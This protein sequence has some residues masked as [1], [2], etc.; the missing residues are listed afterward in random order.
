MMEDLK[1]I[2]NE[3]NRNFDTDYNMISFDSLPSTDLLQILL[4][5]L[6]I[7][8]ASNKLD[9]RKSKDQAIIAALNAL[10]LIKYNPT[11]P[12]DPIEFREGLI[13]G[14]RNII[15]PI[16][17]WIL[18][19]SEKV[20]KRVYFSNFVEK[21]EIPPEIFGDPEVEQMNQ[22]YNK[23]IEEF[24][25]SYNENRQEKKNAEESIE[26]QEDTKKMAVDMSFLL[27]RLEMQN[28]KL[29]NIPNRESLLAS[30]KAYRREIQQEKKMQGQL[31]EHKNLI[32]QM[33]NELKGLH[34]VLNQKM[35]RRPDNA[36]PL[37][38]IR[39]E[40]QINKILGESQLP[41]EQ[42]GIVMELDVFERVA[43]ESEPTQEELDIINEEMEEMSKIVQT[44]LARKMTLTNTND[45]QLLPFRNQATMIANKKQELSNF[46]MKVKS[47]I[48]NILEMINQKAVML[49]EI[50]GGDILHGDEL[51]NFISNLRERSIVYKK[52]RSYLQ[53]IQAE[54]GIVSR[55]LDILKL[56]D[57]GVEVAIKMKKDKL[58]D[59]T[60]LGLDDVAEL[61]YKCKML[62][63]DANSKRVESVRVY[64]DMTQLRAAYNNFLDKFEETKT[65]FD[66]ATG[67]ISKE[68]E[69][70]E[71]M[72]EENAEAIKNAENEWKHIVK[73]IEGYEMCLGKYS[74]IKNGGV[75]NVLLQLKEK[76]AE[77]E[78]SRKVLEMKYE[79]VKEQKSLEQ[80]AIEQLKRIKQMILFKIE[81]MR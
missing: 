2:V 51:K 78:K 33:T 61:K 5:V 80:D 3:L 62:Y 7:V 46:I 19:N 60:D 45:D 79:E 48:E 12:I 49:R 25:I 38:Q 39:E 72:I 40:V 9:V 76:S 41:K 23:F 28:D 10:Q 20:R 14:K 67:N 6:N 30:V 26:L 75:E 11:I 71:R 29:K 37:Q 64:E 65:E 4:D 54:L 50:V 16:L 18:A 42:E 68:L 34:N 77:L 17:F 1:F 70:I 63:Q 53:G 56:S 22:N 43:L 58:E 55:T 57:A 35:S 66:N 52:Y 44:L 15:H 73:D 24:W 21:V 81:I 8:N 74:D 27:Q 31:K 36:D 47:R 69:T 32:V 13:N 59:D